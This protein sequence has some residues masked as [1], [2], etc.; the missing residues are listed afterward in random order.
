MKACSDS[1]VA[2]VCEWYD[3]ADQRFPIKVYVHNPTWVPEWSRLFP[4]ME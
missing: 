2:D 1:G 4:K 3:D